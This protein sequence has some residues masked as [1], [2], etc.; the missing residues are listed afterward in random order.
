MRYLLSIA[1][2]ALLASI[3]SA[4]T[5][6][7]YR[8]LEIQSPAPTGAAGLRLQNNF[9]EL[10]DRI[11][12]SNLTATTAPTTDDDVDEGYYVGS[13]W[14]DTVGGVLY[15]CADNTDGA[16]VWKDLSTAGGAAA[17][18]DAAYAASWDGVTTIAP[19]K[20]A[21]Y[22]YLSG[23]SSVYQAADADLT[24][25]AG[26][27]SSANGRSLVSAADYAAMRT[28]LSL[29]TANTPQFAGLGLGAAAQAGWPLTIE[30]S[31]TTQ[32]MKLGFGG[33]SCQWYLQTSGAT[34]IVA[35][36]GSLALSSTAGSVGLNGYGGGVNL[37]TAAANS[38]SIFAGGFLYVYDIDDNNALRWSVNTATGEIA[39]PSNTVGL[40]LN[41]SGTTTIK[42]DTTNL[43]FVDPT[44]P[45]GKTL[46]QLATDT[47]TLGSIGSVANGD[48]LIYNS[49]WKRLGKGDDGQVLKLASGLPSWAADTDTNY[50]AGNGLSLTGTTFS[51]KLKSGGGL[52]IDTGQLTLT[53]THLTGEIGITIDGAGSEIADGVKGFVRIPY[54]CTI[55]GVYL[56]A[57]Q[58]G[59]IVV[60]V[61]KDT[62]AN[63]PPTVADTITA[64]A[65]PTLSSAI[66]GS[67]TTL[68]DWTKTV[69]AGDVIGFNVDSCTTITRLTLQ[70]VTTK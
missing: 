9:R 56:M 59:S 69:S 50:S 64:S 24:T 47:D 18:S 25:W 39:V 57:D 35:Y 66:S 16:A 44:N 29:A 32:G 11:G 45:A 21:I 36:N 7:N 20:N 42:S 13:L 60:D 4:Q 26:V 22:D 33:K 52:E 63:Y 5:I 37:T 68:T 23:L 41:A 54:A 8:G 62:F 43:T 27:T 17:I 6:V 28:L 40:K 58:S 49:G 48:V 67:D 14:Y 2:L 30:Q 51:T 55:T 65:K 15:W 61:W 53:S 1:I 38:V 46:A 19:S 70:I 34:G 10:A 3:A 12:P 31:V